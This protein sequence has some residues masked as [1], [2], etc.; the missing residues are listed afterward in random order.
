MLDIPSKNDRDPLLTTVESLDSATGGDIAAASALPDSSEAGESSSERTFE[1]L[2]SLLDADPAVAVDKIEDLLDRAR[3]FARGR[4]SRDAEDIAQESILRLA[5][6]V[7]RG[8]DIESLDKFFA[9][10]VKNVWLEGLRNSVPF[11]EPSDI[12]GRPPGIEPTDLITFDR[13]LDNLK[14]EDRE[15]IET[16][17]NAV[18][19]EELAGQLGIAYS[20]LRVRLHRVAK[21][22]RRCY[23]RTFH[24]QVE[25]KVPGNALQGS[26]ECIGPKKTKG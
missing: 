21:Q 5:Q 16:Y 1:K 4:R 18:D 20:T 14:P 12:P 7:N 10:V 11:S 8:A 26:R 17:N 9:G 13:C 19:K 23:G 6:A 22:L 3:A 2:L 24:R 25:T 15:L